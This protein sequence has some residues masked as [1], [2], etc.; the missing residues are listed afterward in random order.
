V[1]GVIGEQPHL[2]DFDSLPQAQQLVE[3]GV[4]EP[5]AVA[6]AREPRGVAVEPSARLGEVGDL[7]HLIVE[8][9]RRIR[10]LVALPARRLA[11]RGTQRVE[12]RARLRL[13]EPGDEVHRQHPRTHL[14]DAVVVGDQPRVGIRR[15]LLVRP[16]HGNVPSSSTR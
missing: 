12:L 4:V 11:Q 8:E 2:V 16:D 13:G 1:V 14:R 9:H 6:G 10:V 5:D 15:A 7:S 3:R